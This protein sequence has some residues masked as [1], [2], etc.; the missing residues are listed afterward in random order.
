MKFDICLLNYFTNNTQCQ[1]LLEQ[2]RGFSTVLKNVYRFSVRNNIFETG[3]VRYERDIGKQYTD[4]FE[5]LYT[6]IVNIYIVQIKINL[7]SV[8]V[9][10]CR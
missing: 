1:I 4:C 7:I 2:Q 5:S 10:F 3:D 9:F 6:H 8:E